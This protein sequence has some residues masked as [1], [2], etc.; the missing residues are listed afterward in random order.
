MFDQ[1]DFE[2]EEILVPKYAVEDGVIV[3]DHQGLVSSSNSERQS[4]HLV[5]KG[6]YPFELEI[7]KSLYLHQIQ[8]VS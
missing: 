5:P 7:D 3:S 2:E 6:L 4:E 8:P 1:N